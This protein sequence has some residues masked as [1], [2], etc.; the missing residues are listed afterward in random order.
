[1]IANG[2]LNFKSAW[3]AWCHCVPTC[4]CWCHPSRWAW[5]IRAS[6]PCS[7]GWEKSV[8]SRGTVRHPAT[9]SVESPAY[10]C[11]LDARCLLMARGLSSSL[12]V[13]CHGGAPLRA[14]YRALPRL[15]IVVRACV[16]VEGG[17]VLLACASLPLVPLGREGTLRSLVVAEFLSPPF[18]RGG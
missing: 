6:P 17:G 9:G 18:F 11:C 10:W 15:G 13:T 2:D 14:E 12:Q 1:M 5:P 7:S 8:W 4:P 3:S 16:C